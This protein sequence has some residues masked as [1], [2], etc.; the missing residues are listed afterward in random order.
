MLWGN[1]GEEFDVDA[2]ERVVAATAE[3]EEEHGYWWG[4]ETLEGGVKEEPREWCNGFGAYQNFKC[5]G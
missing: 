5:G 3:V 1:C 4:R 2:E